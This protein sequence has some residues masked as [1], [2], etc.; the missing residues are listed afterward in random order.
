MENQAEQTKL[1]RGQKMSFLYPI[2]Y[3]VAIV[4]SA[5]YDIYVGGRDPVERFLFYTIVIGV[6][7]NFFISF[8]MHYFN[9][10]NIARGIG[11]PTG[12]PFQKELAWAILGIG[13]A[14]LSCIWFTGDYWLAPVIAATV[15]LWGAAYG[16]I[17]EIVKNKNFSPGNA[18]PVLWMDII[19][20]IVSLTLL[21]YY[22]T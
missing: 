7:L 16:H 21:Y 2:I 22:L 17:K 20:P 4:A 10:D 5:L 9:G 12:S 14:A 15:F 8:F 3:L 19:L 13:L 18:G 11:W 6:G 1:S